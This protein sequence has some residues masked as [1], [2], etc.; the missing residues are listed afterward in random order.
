M[1]RESPTDGRCEATFTRLG[2]PRAGRLLSFVSRLYE[3]DE[4]QGPFA[5]DFDGFRPAIEMLRSVA[6]ELDAR[7]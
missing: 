5:F 6:R 3:R 2:R 7:R 4:R 1:L